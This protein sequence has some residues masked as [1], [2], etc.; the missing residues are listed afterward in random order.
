MRLRWAHRALLAGLALIAAGIAQTFVFAAIAPSRLL[1]VGVLL[2][3]LQ[4]LVGLVGACVATAV[5]AVLRIGRQR[6]RE[7]KGRLAG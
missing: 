4:V 5:I 6:R 1:A 3:W 2:G 7:R